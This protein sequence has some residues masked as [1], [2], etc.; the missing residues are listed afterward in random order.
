MKGGQ[1]IYTFIRY[2]WIGFIPG[3]MVMKI[4]HDQ[5]RLIS[6]PSNTKRVAPADK[7]ERMD[8]ICC[9]TT[10]STSMLIRLNSSK[11]PHAPVCD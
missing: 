8:R 4:P 2:L 10:D 6:R 5:T 3:F 1:I 7:A 11:Q 9:A